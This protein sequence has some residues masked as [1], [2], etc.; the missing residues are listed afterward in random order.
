MP[1]L[2]TT[3]SKDLLGT[4]IADFGVAAAVVRGGKQKNEYTSK[5]SRGH[6]R[7]KKERCKIR[8]TANPENRIILMKCISCGKTKKITARNA[9]KNCDLTIDTFYRMVKK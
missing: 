2:D 4:F 5:T 6:C 1:L 9:A 7:R 8:Q 3:R